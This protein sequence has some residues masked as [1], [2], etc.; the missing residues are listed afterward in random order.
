MEEEK[1]M[2]SSGTGQKKLR[3][4]YVF[5]FPQLLCW[6]RNVLLCMDA[7]FAEKMLGA[8]DGVLSW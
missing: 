6:S 3:Y 5:D 2:T 1:I 8:R 4:F 7:D